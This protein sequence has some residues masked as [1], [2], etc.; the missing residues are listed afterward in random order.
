MDAK[1]QSDRARRAA[2]RQLAKAVHAEGQD[3]VPTSQL[4]DY[5]ASCRM[6]DRNFISQ[7]GIGGSAAAANVA[8]PASVRGKLSAMSSSKASWTPGSSPV[9]RRRTASTSRKMTWTKTA[10]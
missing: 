3:V 7:P 1:H 5:S 10:M 4:S 6:L 8:R 9:H 2:G